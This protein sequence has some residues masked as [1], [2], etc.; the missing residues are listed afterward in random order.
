MRIV[1]RII[2]S[3]YTLLLTV[4]SVG[5]ILLSL[6]FISLEQAASCLF[7]IY[8]QWQAALA[9]AIFL[10]VS[11]RLLLA[12]L[13]SRSSSDAIIHN[14]ELGQVQISIAAVENLVEKAARH[15]KG[16]REVKVKVFLRDNGINI[17]LRTVI[18]PECN[19]PEVAAQ[20]QQKV[21][22]HLQETV[23]VEA[24]QVEIKVDDISND[25]KLKQRVE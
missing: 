10:L 5:V 7:Y 17:K 24:A 11:I 1:D 16:V 20:I 21:Y 18:S 9:G 15:I 3:L 12:G 22:K 19:V 4:L 13:R 14:N 23:G 25:F 2:L 6:R 8:D